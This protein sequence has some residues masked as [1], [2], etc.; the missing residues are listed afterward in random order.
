MLYYENKF[1][2]IEAKVEIANY[3]QF[4][5]FSE[6]FQTSSAAVSSEGVYMLQWVNIYFSMR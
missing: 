5:R 1:K 6:C 4:L 3:E 2:N